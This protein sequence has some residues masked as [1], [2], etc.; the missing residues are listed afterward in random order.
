MHSTKP[1]TKQQQPAAQHK[2]TPGNQ[3]ECAGDCVNGLIALFCDDVDADAFCPNEG[4]C[5]ITSEDKLQTT[6]PRITT[7]VSLQNSDK[8]PLITQLMGMLYPNQ[9]PPP[10][11]P[12]FCLLNIMAAFCERPSV[13]IP[14]TTN[15]NK[16]SV[17]CD[18]SR[19]STT[20]RPRPPP[21]RPT[22]TQS[23]T[24]TTTPIPDPREDCPGTC[25]VGLLSFTCFRNA[26]MT[27][28]FK[29][30]KSGTKCCAPKTRIQEVHTLSRND[31]VY[32]FNNQIPHPPLQGSINPQ[33]Q[34]PPLPPFQGHPNQPQYNF[35]AQLPHN[36]NYPPPPQT[37]PQ[38][39][40][41][42][43]PQH[44]HTTPFYDIS[45][46]GA[47]TTIRP[48][49]YSK[50]VCG[51]KGNSRTSRRFKLDARE[52][53]RSR[54][55]QYPGMNSRQYPAMNKTSEVLTLGHDVVPFTI[56]HDLIQ[57]A[58]IPPTVNNTQL[59]T[60]RKGRVVGG[61]DGENGEWC[62]QVALINSLNQYLCGAALIG[63][64]WVLTAAHCVT[65]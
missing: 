61:E 47:T 44:P 50:Y 15:C 34:P 36:P 51:V 7:P 29:C 23:T 52:A 58:D 33:Q 37:P 55:Y 8:N 65:K 1:S 41:Q 40:A 42:Q 64:Q 2:E 45:N 4:S 13:I 59:N 27:D 3:N 31:T 19:I 10:R 62:W 5:C 49:I 9:P 20:T 6:T 38:L 12:G 57:F 56:S 43:I 46:S 25:I 21:R 60:M 24:T 17:C 14:K 26:E 16:G 53:R 22:T 11:C 28:L 18:D 35:G 39:P 32:P 48:M 63:T 54:S 30:A